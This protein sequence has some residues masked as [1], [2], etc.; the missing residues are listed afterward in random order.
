MKIHGEGSR[1]E[2]GRPASAPE[3][4]AAAFGEARPLGSVAANRSLD[5]FFL[6]AD[7]NDLGIFL[8]V[9]RARNAQRIGFSDYATAGFKK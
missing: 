3:P 8:H 5:D 1:A 4:R 9:L 7:F 2:T 6:S